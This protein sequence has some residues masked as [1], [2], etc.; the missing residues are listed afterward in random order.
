MGVSEMNRACQR[1]YEGI[2]AENRAREEAMT[3]A[4]RAAKRRR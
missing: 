1:V 3:E 4:K 2:M